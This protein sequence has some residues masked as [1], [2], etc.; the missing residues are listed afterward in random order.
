MHSLLAVLALFSGALALPI[1]PQLVDE[2]EG[3]I[4]YLP[5]NGGW[6]NFPFGDVGSI[7]PIMFNLYCHGVMNITDLYCSG[8]RFA[9]YDNGVLLGDTSHPVFNGCASNSSHP[10]Y[11]QMQGNWSHGS[12]HL[13]PGWHNVSIVIMKSPYGH[14]IGS[15]RVDSGRDQRERQHPNNHKHHHHEKKCTVDVCPHVRS[16]L[17]VVNTRVPR[18]QA[19]QV[20]KSLG[21][22]LANIDVNNFLDATTLAYQCSGANSESWVDDWNGVN[23][24]G[25][26]LVLSTGNAAPGGAI[27]APSCCSAHLPVICQKKPCSHPSVHYSCNACKSS[28]YCEQKGC[29]KCDHGV[30]H[31]SRHCGLL[32]SIDDK[33]DHKMRERHEHKKDHHKEHDYKEREHGHKK[34]DDHEDKEHDRRY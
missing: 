29:K 19:E 15:I 30:C 1:A 22:H 13:L 2:I 14:G 12:F 18:C 5:V 3:T 26:C 32:R 6:M 27:N 20:C 9:I 24:Q 7:T 31:E 33:Y 10:G 11:T 25:T 28:C 16:D 34:D 4:G 23:Y 17:V 21:M 8:D